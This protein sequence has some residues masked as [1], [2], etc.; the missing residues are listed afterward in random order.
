MNIHLTAGSI[1]RHLLLIALVVCSAFGTETARAQAPVVTATLTNNGSSIVNITGNQTFTLTLTINTNFVWGG[2]TYFFQVNPAGS[3]LFRIIARDTTGSPYPIPDPLLCPGNACLLD[4]TNNFDLGAGPANINDT[5]PP[6]T[7]TIATYTL[8]A[9]N[10]PIGQYFI[11]TDRGVVT[12][13]TD[14]TFN[15]RPFSTGITINVVPE[16]SIISL[17]LLGGAGVLMLLWRKQRQHL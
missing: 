13:R 1:R 5:T 12:D 14:D 11:S 10:A 6:G 4:P 17:S 3:G 9:E 16:P 8:R 7:Y 2:L 15:D